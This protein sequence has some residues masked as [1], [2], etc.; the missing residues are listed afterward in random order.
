[1]EPHQY[2]A[3]KMK[4]SIILMLFIIVLSNIVTAKSVLFYEI[5]LTYDN[6]NI[7]YNS[8]QVKPAISSSEIE[9]I[10]GGYVAEVINFNDEILN[11]TFFD[12]PLTILYDSI[13]PETEEIDSGGIINLNKTEVT[14]KVPYYENAKEINIYDKNITKKLT[15]D[16]S[17]FSKEIPIEKEEKIIEKE[18]IPIKEEVKE[19]AKVFRK[20]Y[21]VY[22]VIIIMILLIFIFVMKKLRKEP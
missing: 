10:V 1:M 2:L 18:K 7:T 17:Y 6:E 19:P 9:N 11:Y 12:I 5:K 4:K 14:I 13:N 22:G 15:I 21:I 16:V 8:I 20:S 3:N